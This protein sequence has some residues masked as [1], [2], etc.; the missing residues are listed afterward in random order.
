M[1]IYIN[2]NILNT[3][4]I[5]YHGSSINLKI[6]DYILPPNTQG[7]L[8]EKGRKKNLDKIFFTK[9]IKS[10]KIYAGRAYNSLGGDGKYVYEIEPIG[11]ITTLNDQKGT[12]VYNSDKAKI[13]KKMEI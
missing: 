12:T 2:E 3:S 1:K 4:P 10:A 9:D 13:L 6:G 8:S 11:E 5:F 7:N